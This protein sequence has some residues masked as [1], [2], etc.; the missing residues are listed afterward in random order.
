M[1][2]SEY[3]LAISRDVTTKKE[4]EESLRKSEARLRTT[5]D[6]IPMDFW[7]MDEKGCYI[8]QNESSKR[9]W[10]N[11][12]GKTID[13]VNE[14]VEVVEQWRINNQR[15]FNGESVKEEIILTIK[16]Q[17]K[18]YINI[19]QPIWDGKKVIGI[20]GTNLNISDLRETEQAL[21][22]SEE[23]LRLALEA[24]RAAMWDWDGETGVEYFSP[25]HF[26]ILGYS[27]GEIPFTLESWQSRLHPDDKETIQQ[28]RSVMIMK[29]IDNIDSEIRI[30]DKNENWLWILSRLKVVKRNEFGYPLRII[31]TN[32]EVTS[33][34]N[35]E[36]EK[37][38]LER[39]ILH[40]Q[41]L[42]SL[43][44]LAGGIAH[45]FNNILLAILGNL[46]LAALEC[47]QNG[48]VYNKIMDAENAAKRASELT[49]QMLAYSGKGKFIISS[50]SLTQMIDEMM[51]LL[52]TSI[53]KHATLHFDLAPQ[54]PLITAD[55]SQIQQI[56]MN[57][58]INASEAIGEQ[59]GTINVRTGVEYYD[60]EKLHASRLEMKPEPGDF[61]FL[62]IED[63]GCGMDEDTINRLF[64]PFFSTK[65]TGRG[66]GMS[67]VL[68]IVSGHKG[69]IFINSQK[70]HGTIFKILFPVADTNTMIDKREDKMDTSMDFVGDLTVL[71]IDDEPMV[72][73][74]CREMLIVLGC[75]ALIAANG[76][77][78]IALFEEKKDEID[79]IILDYTMP[80]LDGV[81]TFLKLKEI[82]QEVRVILSSGYNS[83]EL[84]QQFSTV[85][86]TGFIQKPFVMDS[87]KNEI[88]KAKK[89]REY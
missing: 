80:K 87:L 76:E 59:N 14:N 54:L 82:K 11:L 65:F 62:E 8:L 75:K 30:R 20:I 52:N 63:T 39:K 37:L 43:G 24:S 60:K 7:A 22:D 36:Q 81:A 23:R 46:E 27:T 25:D 86:F 6:S 61:V 66:L 73:T 57:V 71:I 19:V 29:G 74:L 45:D 38:A 83:Q 56:I 34:K 17:K 89:P 5:M 64:D 40:T 3:V 79:M 21:R 33:R 51:N 32:H 85:G 15:A 42:E 88:L 28:Q 2:D 70:G 55:A 72:R 50:M 47:K 12:V 10:G 18:P 68:G 49:T 16:G 58:A 48:S 77:E 4:S 1:I 35:E 67:A 53:S 44:I 69:A 31:G 78:G 41:R 84:E 13:I 26:K 9:I